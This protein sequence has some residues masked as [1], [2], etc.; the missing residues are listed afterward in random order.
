MAADATSAIWGHVR[1]PRPGGITG[2][3]RGAELAPSPLSSGASH[4]G[5]H[6]LTHL[7]PVEES[8][9]ISQ[10]LGS[11][12]P[13]LA[14]GQAPESPTLQAP[15]PRRP[16]KRPPR[17]TAAPPPR[18]DDVPASRPS[19]HRRPLEALEP[20]TSL[21]APGRQGKPPTDGKGPKS[22]LPR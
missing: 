19:H 20:N 18:P 3:T 11:L 22:L 5:L 12:P 21:G 2:P 8:A 14:R 13:A 7:I 10:I 15:A 4:D 6:V 9:R 17:I 1:L 16:T